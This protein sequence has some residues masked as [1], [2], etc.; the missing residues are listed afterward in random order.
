MAKKMKKQKTQKKNIEMETILKEIRA[1]PK[2]EQTEDRVREI[3]N[4]Q[5][6]KVKNLTTN[7]KAYLNMLKS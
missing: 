5:P 2:E 1:L 4:R 6:L 7:D 3:V